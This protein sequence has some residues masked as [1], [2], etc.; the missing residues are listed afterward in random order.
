MRYDVRLGELTCKM[1]IRELLPQLKELDL[2]NHLMRRYGM[3]PWS[4]CGGVT[5]DQELEDGLVLAWW[6]A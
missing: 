4:M 3:A 6:C 2:V 5:Q 1:Q